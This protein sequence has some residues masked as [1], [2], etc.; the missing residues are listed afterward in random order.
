MGKTQKNSFF[1]KNA[2]FLVLAFVSVLFC[3]LTVLG[4]FQ[5]YEQR[6]YDMLLGMT[7]EPEETEQILLVE[8]DD[9]SIEEIG[10][11]PWTRDILGNALLRMKE[12][13]A[14]TAVFDIEYLEPSAKATAADAEERVLN[15]ISYGEAQISQAL[16]QMGTEI[17][18]G[19]RSVPQSQIHQFLMDSVLRQQIDPVFYSLSREVLDTLSRNNDQIFASDVQ[20][21]GNA[22]LTMNLRNV[23]ANPTG[24]EYATERFLWDIVSDPDNLIEQGNEA[25][26][27]SEIEN[28][29]E[30]TVSSQRSL[31]PALSTIIDHAAGAGF[32]NVY[33]D[34]DGTRRRIELLNQYDGKYAGQLSFSPLL[35]YLS[36]EHIERKKHSLVLSGV[37]F[38]GSDKTKTITIPLDEHGRMLINWQHGEYADSFR[39]ESVMFLYLLDVLEADSVSCVSYLT[40]FLPLSASDEAAALLSEADSLLA[41]YADVEDYLSFLLSSCYGFDADG[42]VRNG[43]G[44]TQSDYDQYF[45]L[46]TSFYEAMDTFAAGVNSLPSV[47]TEEESEIYG[48]YYTE[49]RDALLSNWTVFREYLDDMKSVYDGS[50]CFIGFTAA[51]STDFGVTPF[52]RSYA[53]LGTHAN[54]FNTIMQQDFITPVSQ[55]WLIALTIILCLATIIVCRRIRSAGKKNILSLVYVVIPLVVPMLLMVCFKVS[56][57]FLTAVL[58]GAVTYLVLMALRFVDVINQSAFLKNTFGAY[59]APEVVSQIIKNPEVAQLGGSDKNITALFSDV[60]SFSKFS[61]TVNDPVR[62]VQILNEYLGALSDAIMDNRGT[63]DKY[64]GDEIVSFFGAPLENPSHAFDALCAGIRMKQAEAEY[65]K[66]H[67]E[68]DHDIPF[69]LESRVGVNSGLMVVGNMGTEKKLNYTIMGNNVNLASRLEGVNKVYGTWIMCSEN[70]WKQADTGKNEGILLSRRLDKVRVININTPVQIYSILGKKSDLSPEVIE[71]AEIFN[72]GSDLYLQGDFEQ[73]LKLFRDAE[74]CYAADPSSKVF[75]ERCQQFIQSGKPD[76]WDGVYTMTSK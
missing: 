48:D 10:T 40:D 23:H 64:V 73:A 59:V 27:R 63:I 17:S 54:V 13:G 66:K 34:P 12:L 20:F 19:K 2:D 70:T 18:S 67:F 29:K 62:L 6:L 8:V 31:I 50:V 46:R 52:S 15:A 35:N 72:K 69:A 14:D 36:V 39:H 16:D 74:R 47:F 75:A 3:I 24:V 51:A 1:K 4:A 56:M 5:R 25:T 60:K 53:N 32:T 38:P 58:I 43:T 55:W 41:K 21:F 7:K 44:I 76:N 28:L 11:W 49:A 42:T 65:N 26:F 68:T 30:E 33:V 71:A 37:H 22:W 45:A 61:E 9:D 57:P